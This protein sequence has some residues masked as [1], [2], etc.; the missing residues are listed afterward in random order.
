MRVKIVLM[1]LVLLFGMN[2]LAA[3]AAEES[4]WVDNELKDYKQL[5][6]PAKDSASAHGP[7]TAEE[8]KSFHNNVLNAAKFDEPMEI[9][10]WATGLKMAMDLPEER[11]DAL[12]Q[13]YVYGLAV[14]YPQGIRREDAVGGLV[15]LLTIS[16]LKGNWSGEELKPAE[17]IKD[18]NMISDR[19]KVLVQ[20]AYA[21][22]ILDTNTKE[23][24]RPQD[25]LTNA[26]AISM[27]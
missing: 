4:H 13:M 17:A 22:G 11:I 15:K 12:L 27:L 21:E 7:I 18:M 9:Y 26:E 14:N 23:T 16:H 20:I 25:K 1:L 2:G 19:Q 6:V 8:W 5:L 10:Q 3:A 24:F